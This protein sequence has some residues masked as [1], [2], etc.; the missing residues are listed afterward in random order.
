MDW[1]LFSDLGGPCLGADFKMATLYVGV[2]LLQVNRA[3]SRGKTHGLHRYHYSTY[4]SLNAT[5][6]NVFLPESQWRDDDPTVEACL[7]CIEPPSRPRQ[8][9]E[10]KLY[11][12][13]REGGRP[14]FSCLSQTAILFSSWA[15]YNLAQ[16]GST[17]RLRWSSHIVFLHPASRHFSTLKGSTGRQTQSR[18]EKGL[19]DANTRDI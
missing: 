2:W 17:R 11:Q 6:C 4:S 9:V 16:T 10:L 1:C 5:D 19:K 3:I 15:I 14:V 13:P 8:V 12:H 18:S 7:C